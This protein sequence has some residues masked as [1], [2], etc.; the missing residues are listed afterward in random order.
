MEYY[1][2]ENVIEYRYGK[3]FKVQYDKNLDINSIFQPE[4][5][6]PEATEEIYSPYKDCLSKPIPKEMNKL[7]CRSD[8]PNSTN[9]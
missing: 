5:L 7:F 8:S 3:K 9:K 6:S 2:D 1:E 4:R